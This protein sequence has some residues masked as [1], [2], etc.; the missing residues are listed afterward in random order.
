M[1]TQTNQKKKS[2]HL[3]VKLSTLAGCQT[4]MNQS[5]NNLK[6]KFNNKLE[7]KL[8]NTN[9]ESITI[10]VIM[11]K[12]DIGLKGRTRKESKKDDKKTKNR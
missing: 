11:L 1:K 7:P 5:R 4:K 12:V 9:P 3:R 6:N 8:T 2:N 10:I